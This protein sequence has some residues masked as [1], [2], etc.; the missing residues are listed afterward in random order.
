[1]KSTCCGG[2]RGVDREDEGRRLEAGSWIGVCAARRCTRGLS[3]L[4][5]SKLMDVKNGYA[6]EV[7]KELFDAEGVSNRIVPPLASDAPMSQPREIWVP[8]SKTHVAAEIMRKI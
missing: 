5:W 3:R 7:W 2:K 6:A 1:M 4:M 8:D